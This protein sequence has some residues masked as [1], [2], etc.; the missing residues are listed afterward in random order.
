MTTHEDPALPAG[1][2]EP[3]KLDNLLINF[4]TEFHRVWDTTGARGKSASFW[5]PT[6]APDALPG[7]FSLG[8]IAISGSAN[9]NGEIIAAVVCEGDSGGA[10]NTRKRAL[11]RPSDF[12]LVWK[13]TGSA[14]VTRTS[15]WRPVAPTGYVALGL[16]CSNDHNKPS[17][18]TVRCVRKDLVVEANV[19][20]L[21]WNDKGSGAKMSFSAWH[22]EP[23]TATAGEICFAPGTFVGSPNHDKPAAP[24]NAYA[25]RM[26]IPLEVTPPPEAPTLGGY[27]KPQ[28]APARITQTAK[29]PWF[30]IR[31]FERPSEQFQKSPYYTLKRTDQHLLVGH[32]HN[33]TGKCQPIKW[34]ARRAQDAALMRIFSRSTSVEVTKAWPISA[35]S[36]VRMT[37]FSACLHKNFTHTETSLSGWSELRPQLVLA[38]APR[39]KSVA[40]YQ[41]E[42]YYELT[43]E[44][45]TLVA[46]EFGYSDDA[47]IYLTEYPA[48]KEEPVVV[49]PALTT[50]SPI[51]A[52]AVHNTNE[53]NVISAPEADLLGATDTLP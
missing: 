2:M 49:C 26:Q 11:S 14:A 1:Q 21:I 22:I 30:A 33:K 23:P 47:S 6:P 18:N 29:L 19:G 35:L 8:D 48:E 15:I 3:I 53:I 4:T 45:G 5:R 20:D 44:D 27:E 31:D 37:K 9:I 43:R 34:T 52:D 36:D 16:V 39:S 40:I 17:L 41:M 12:E 25:L 13:E 10:A 28:H 42:S 46:V 38:M 24:P 50:D 51:E 32:C 7:Y